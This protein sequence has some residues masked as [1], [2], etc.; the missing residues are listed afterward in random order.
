MHHSLPGGP[1]PTPVRRPAEPS[2]SAAKHHLPPYSN[3]A[4]GN[5]TP[6]DRVPTRDDILDRIEGF[7]VG[8]HLPKTSG[9][10]QHDENLHWPRRPTHSHQ[11]N[12]REY[13]PSGGFLMHATRVIYNASTPTL[14]MRKRSPYV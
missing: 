8:M 2:A 11:K 14:S 9:L 10:I 5:D 6:V 12:F 1:L 7:L 13:L 3:S 4:H